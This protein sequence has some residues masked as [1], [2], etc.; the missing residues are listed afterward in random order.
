MSEKAI[1]LRIIFIV[2]LYEEE[3]FSEIRE[4]RLLYMMDAEG[5]QPPVID[6]MMGVNMSCSTS[7]TLLSYSLP[8]SL[9]CL[10]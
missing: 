7:N 1:L 8:F 4:A 2:E 6:R 10:L 5:P 9:S 3:Y